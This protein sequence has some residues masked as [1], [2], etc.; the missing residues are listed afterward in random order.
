MALRRKKSIQ[1][2]CPKDS[3][4]N[5]GFSIFSSLYVINLAAL[6]NLHGIAIFFATPYR[7][8]C[9]RQA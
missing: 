4:F 8:G 3:S 1:M 9:R 7:L 5:N 6:Y 2:L